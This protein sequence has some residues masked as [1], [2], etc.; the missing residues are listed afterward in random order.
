LPI[1][2]D[3]GVAADID[4]AVFVLLVCVLEFNAGE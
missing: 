4:A 1:I 3:D 2:V